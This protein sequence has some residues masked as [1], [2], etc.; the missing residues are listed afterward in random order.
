VPVAFNGDQPALP[1][2][3]RGKSRSPRRFSFER[4]LKSASCV[5]PIVDGRMVEMVAHPSDAL[6][7]DIRG[8]PRGDPGQATLQIRK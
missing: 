8:V 2:R 5:T 4:G 3:L 6:A 1:D 7:V